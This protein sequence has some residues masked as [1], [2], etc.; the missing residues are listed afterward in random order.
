MARPTTKPEWATGASAA[1][2]TPSAGKISGGWL[3][4]E[5][6][7][8]QYHNW[9]F[10][11]G[12]QWINFFDSVLFQEYGGDG[13]HSEDGTHWEVSVKGASGVS[14]L[15]VYGVN[16][17]SSTTR[18]F[19]VYDEEGGTEVFYISNNL[20]AV[21]TG[22]FTSGNFNTSGNYVGTGTISAGGA[23]S[24]DTVSQTDTTNRTEVVPGLV[25]ELLSSGTRV[26]SGCG[27]GYD[28]NDAT[29]RTIRYWA[30]KMPEH[31]LIRGV[32]V[33][34]QHGNAANSVDAT[35]YSCDNG[36][37]ATATSRGTISTLTSVTGAQ[38]SSITVSGSAA[39]AGAY[40]WWV[41]VELTN[42]DASEVYCSKVIWQ[43][44]IQRF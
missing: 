38:S 42:S 27:L 40:G 16:G 14:K 22:T 24:G 26:E 30:P 2:S 6:P 8:H 17:E 12:Y 1:L 20:Q 25:G 41:D 44:D 15:T 28:E 11:W 29:T 34:T 19:S 35:L 37:N 3:A 4:A 32:D 7:P 36:T 13:Q 33:I 23:V 5:K 39:Q 43:Y 18:M 21:F 10:Y 9:L 31:A